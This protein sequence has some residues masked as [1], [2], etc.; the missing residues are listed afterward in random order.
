MTIDGAPWFVAADCR[1]VL[2]LSHYGGMYDHLDDAEKQLCGRA[3]LNLGRGRAVWL[4]SESGLYK[5]V[6]RSDKSQ[7]NAGEQRGQYPVH[8]ETA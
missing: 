8:P 1:D 7:A 3:S 6:M 4:I 5:L 2:G